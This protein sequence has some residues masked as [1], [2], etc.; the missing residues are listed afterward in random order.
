[1]SASPL[2]PLVQA[3]SGAFGAV[4]SNLAVYPLDTAVSRMQTA[5]RPK[6]GKPNPYGSLP[7]AVRILR[8]TL[9]NRRI[10]QSPQ[11]LNGSKG[12]TSAAPILTAVEEIVIGMLSGIAAKAVVSPLSN[13]TVRQQTATVAKEKSVEKVVDRSKEED[14]SDEDDD[15]GSGSAPSALDIA[16][17]ILKE[18][19]CQF[20]LVVDGFKSSLV[21]SINPALSSYLLEAFKRAVIPVKHLEHPTPAQVFLTSAFASS[22]ASALTYPMILSKSRLMF[23][24]PSG[25]R[26][27]KSNV[28]VFRKTLKRYGLIGLYAGLTGQVVKGFFAEGIKM[29]IKDRLE[30]LIVLAHRIITR[31]NRLA[32]A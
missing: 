22:V 1:M 5:G 17:D 31:Q 20:T 23:K 10:K 28:D 27:Y 11:P 25:K 9:I 24:S 32:K 18:K 15:G 14:S 13:I 8:D 30:L 6:A 16:K 21:L 4:L 26:L 2:P 12:K 19:A 29:T 3:S 7:Q